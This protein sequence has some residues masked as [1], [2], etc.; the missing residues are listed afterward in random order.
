MID[1]SSR[2]MRR[3]HRIILRLDRHKSRN[4]VDKA[5]RLLGWLVC[6][7]IPLTIT[8]AGQALAVRKGC[9]EQTYKSATKLNPV[10]LLGPIVETVGTYIHFVHLTAKE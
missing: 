8:E 3:Y 10:K 2:A 4:Q 6:S 7:P 5:K 1:L 9:P